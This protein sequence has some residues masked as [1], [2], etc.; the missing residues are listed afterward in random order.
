M[1]SEEAA[2]EP[3]RQIIDPHLHFWD[4]LP[5]PGAL[6]A[7]QRFLLPECLAMVAAS[8]HKVTHT[9]FVE[10]H[11]MYR[12]DAAPEL[13]CVGETEFVTGIAAMSASGNYGPARYAHRIVGSADLRL[14]ARV[15]PVI[16]AH[17]AVAGSR[18]R[19]I[20][21][22]LAYSEAGLFGYPCD[23]ATRGIML[24]P[25]F[26]EGARVLAALDLSLDVWC[27]HSQ[28][29]E[30][31]ALADALPDLAIILDHVGTPIGS[32]AETRAAWG[33]SIA[34]LARRPNVRVKLGGMG[35]DLAGAIPAGTG[36]GRSEVLAEAWRPR[37]ETCIAAFTPA[38]AMFESNFP[39]DKAAG[40]YGA[41]WNAFKRIAQGYSE[42]EKDRLFRGTAAETYR[43]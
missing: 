28:L 37:V 23:P 6:Q 22:G 34:E 11:Q 38:R 43:F 20:R 9:V 14:G 35:M 33:A 39:P 30:L 19:G 25:E 24:T 4:I 21:M 40:S 2:L 36:A 29:P 10:C 42:D 27:V 32:D 18:F 13:A 3:E 7:P 5:A 12:Q 17:L 26:R 1:T 8:G 16:E 31:I 41:T 15:R